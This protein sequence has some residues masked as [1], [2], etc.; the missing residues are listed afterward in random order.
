MGLGTKR[1]VQRARFGV[2]DLP[3][4]LHRAEVHAPSGRRLLFA[5]VAG[6]CARAASGAG[7]VTFT[8]QIVRFSI[9]S[10][11]LLVL[12]K[13]FGGVERVLLQ[14]RR[15]IS[16]IRTSLALACAAA[17]WAQEPNPTQRLNQQQSTVVQ[18]GTAEAPIFRMTVVQRT[19]QAVNYRHRS[20]ST[21]VDLRGTE[22]M[23]EARGKAKVN[24]KQGRLE[25]DADMNHM[26]TPGTY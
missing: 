24:S 22:L 8:C 18:S 2:G 15:G 6:V 3:G 16:M 19:T 11:R 23:P 13:R 25:V 1:G 21:E 7:R 4:H 9:A 14:R 5:G 10:S 20:G 26:S 12:C 17:L